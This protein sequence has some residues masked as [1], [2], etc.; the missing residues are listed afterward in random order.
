MAQVFDAGSLADVDG[1]TLLSAKTNQEVEGPLL[2]AWTGLTHDV[3][4]AHR[5]GLASGRGCHGRRM[6]AQKV[7]PPQERL[8]PRQ[9]K[10]HLIAQTN[11]EVPLF[12]DGPDLHHKAGGC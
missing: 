4:D 1:S 12:S 6:L 3:D 5:G 2:V 8:R 7:V 9:T 10:T 11:Q